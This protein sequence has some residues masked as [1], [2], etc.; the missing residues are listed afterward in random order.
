MKRKFSSGLTL[1]E[2]LVVLAILSILVGVILAAVDPFEQKKK[3]N[4]ALSKNTSIEFIQA[5]LRYYTDNG[6]YPWLS[7]ACYTG[8]T[9][10]ASGPTL[11]SLANCITTISGIGDL[12]TS[13]NK[14]PPSILS[15]ILI[16]DPN[17]QIPT[18]NSTLEACFQPQSSSGQLDR[19]TK[20][21]SAGVSGACTVNLNASPPVTCYYCIQ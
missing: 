5:A 21:S 11:A 18:D 16:F 20:Y 4:D 3:A 13:F 15:G 8:Q 12:K 17:P 2:I 19:N 14:I 7:S 9:P 10:L 1:V 6:S